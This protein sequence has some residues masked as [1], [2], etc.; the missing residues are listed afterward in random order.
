MVLGV[1]LASVR[2]EEKQSLL[3]GGRGQRLAKEPGTKPG[4]VLRV[5]LV[6]YGHAGRARSSWSG[7]LPVVTRVRP[8]SAPNTREPPEIEIPD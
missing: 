2:R 4:F 3:F 6:G 5:F 8:K 1:A 7:T